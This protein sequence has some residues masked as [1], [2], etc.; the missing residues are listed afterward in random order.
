M[1]EAKAA[2]IRMDLASRVVPS[3]NKRQRLLSIKSENNPW[4]SVK[5][6]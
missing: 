2:L 4:S 6:R 5:L 1:L 3:W